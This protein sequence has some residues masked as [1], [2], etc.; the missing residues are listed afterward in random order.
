MEIPSWRQTCC[1]SDYRGEL[2]I[3]VA[4]AMLFSDMAL[5]AGC[6][7]RR[8]VAI[9]AAKRFAEHESGRI[10]GLTRYHPED[11]ESVLTLPAADAATVVLEMNGTR[12]GGRVA[13]AA[14]ALQL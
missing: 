14:E 5:Y 6:P 3:S 8:Q 2:A 12:P 11:G 1:R 4:R 7:P 10:P 9:L 13:S